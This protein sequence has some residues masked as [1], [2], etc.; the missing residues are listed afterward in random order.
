[1]EK[2]LD[3]LEELIKDDDKIITVPLYA[4]IANLPY[5]KAEECIIK[6][7]EVNQGSK[8][9]HPTYILNGIQK[10]TGKISVV[11]VSEETH[12]NEKQTFESN[13]QESIFSIQKAKDINYNIIS[14]VE[15]DIESKLD[16]IK[17]GALI[18]KNC[19]KRVIKKGVVP[20]TCG[21]LTKEKSIVF[22]SSSKTVSKE[23]KTEEQNEHNKEEINKPKANTQGSIANLFNNAAQNKKK[24]KQPDP[25]P[26]SVK[27]LSNFLIKS[28]TK[29][30]SDSLESIKSETKEEEC[31][32][33]KEEKLDLFDLDTDE[34]ILKDLDI[35]TNKCE[36]SKVEKGKKPS[37]R[38]TTKRSRAVKE[39]KSEK[40]R[41]RIII[42]EESES[43]D[44]FGSDK[45]DA[46]D[47][48]IEQ[49]FLE[50]QEP[51]PKPLPPKNKR[52]K[53]VKNTYEDDEGFIVTQTEYIYETASEDEYEPNNKIAKHEEPI[54]SKLQKKGSGSSGNDT[55]PNK[56]TAKANKGSK[57][58]VSK[59]NQPT[60]MNFFKK[61]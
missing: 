42:D 49:T 2:H 54:K 10:D 58:K 4:T 6:F 19:I 60:L 9:I 26:V 16:V 11:L 43:D 37:Q 30:S 3:K 36:P 39:G 38:K 17:L 32:M 8:E 21:P 7:L 47:D 33:K 23:I 41:K 15:P 31:V 35:P 59:T 45:S 57:N 46:E 12:M 40:K 52:R 14:L 53:A 13:V 44:I 5:K 1:M 56:V 51:P 34:D 18:G 20:S 50:E 29:N 55:S 28:S 22:N 25:K 24:S 61:E 48:L 27:G